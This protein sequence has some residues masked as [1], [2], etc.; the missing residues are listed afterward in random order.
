[1]KKRDEFNAIFQRIR[2]EVIERDGKCCVKCKSTLSLEV[3]HI[4]GYS[5]NKPEMLATLCYLCH[6]VAPMEKGLFK[7]WLIIGETGIDVLR[8]RLAAA[9]VP[10]MR[11]VD[12]EKFCGALIEFGIDTNKLKLK[13]A[14]DRLERAGLLKYGRKPYGFKHGEGDILDKIKEQYAE[15]KNPEQIARRLNSDGVFAR[16]GKPWRAATVA[17]ILKREGLNRPKPHIE[18]IQQNSQKEHVGYTLKETNNGGVWAPL[19]MN[20]AELRQC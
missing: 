19:M 7:Q 8:K 9:G 6:G 2:P 12:I 1:M 16:S 14:R 20:G 10:K 11:R 17:K 3:H 13:T 18:R 4:E 5:N 15:G